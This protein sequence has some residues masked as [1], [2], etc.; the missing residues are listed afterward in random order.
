MHVAKNTDWV[1][2]PVAHSV[3]MHTLIDS[4]GNVAISV[5]HNERPRRAS[6]HGALEG[7][8]DSRVCIVDVSFFRNSVESWTDS[9]VRPKKRKKREEK[10]VSLELANNLAENLG[11]F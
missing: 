11:T 10:N 1:F 7:D 4:F 5:E 8:D 9:R 2:E 3:A 6:S